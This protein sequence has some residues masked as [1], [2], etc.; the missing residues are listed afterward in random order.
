MHQLLLVYTRA[1]ESD[2]EM[3]QFEPSN[4]SI[5]PDERLKTYWSRGI[6][7]RRR[8]AYWYQLLTL[9]Y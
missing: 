2:T 6:S 5:L 9:P 1:A 3:L 7:I 4:L 8:L